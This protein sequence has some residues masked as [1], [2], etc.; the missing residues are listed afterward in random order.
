MLNV[1][2]DNKENTLINDSFEIFSELITNFSESIRKE[3]AIVHSKAYMDFLNN[4]NFIE[5]LNEENLDTFNLLVEFNNNA[6]KT[7]L[8]EYK[9]ENSENELINAKNEITNSI[10]IGDSTVE[11]IYLNVLSVLIA[12]D[13]YFGNYEHAFEMLSAAESIDESIPVRTLSILKNDTEF[14]DRFEDCVFSLIVLLL[15]FKEKDRLK[16]SLLDIR[17]RQ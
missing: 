4:N 2:R 9:E 7:I 14:V 5:F 11:E 8:E 12:L 13:F 17:I 6:Y 16:T 1:L 10:N 3:E 15:D